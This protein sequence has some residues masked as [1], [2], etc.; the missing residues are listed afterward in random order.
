MAADARV[1]GEEP[2]AAQSKRLVLFFWAA[3]GRS[4]HE[5]VTCCRSRCSLCDGG[6]AIQIACI[7][8]TSCWTGIMGFLWE[9][10]SSSKPRPSKGELRNEAMLACIWFSVQ[11]PD[12]LTVRA[13]AYL[14]LAHMVVGFTPDGDP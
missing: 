9:E 8:E 7:A 2:L 12:M 5:V 3:H 13:Q 1:R 4:R 14:A 11:V 6:F 10:K